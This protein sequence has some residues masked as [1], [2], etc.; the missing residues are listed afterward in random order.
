[1]NPSAAETGP[2][3]AGQS[4]FSSQFQQ[5]RGSWYNTWAMDHGKANA[6]LRGAGETCPHYGERTLSRRVGV[7][8]TIG[9]PS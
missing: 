4:A 2:N 6:I 8:K 9:T 7:S 5:F 3:S 1:M